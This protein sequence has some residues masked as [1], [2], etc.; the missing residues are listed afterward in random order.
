MTQCKT[1]E[2]ISQ[3]VF[4]LGIGKPVVGQFDGGMISSD[5]GLVL[6]RQADERMQLS[7]QIGFCLGDPRKDTLVRHQLVSIIRQRLYAIAAG[8]E[9]VNDANHL[10]H[11]AMHQVAVG[12]RPGIM[13]ASQPTIS[14]V[15]NRVTREEI[16]FLQELLVHAYVQQFKKAP[17]KVVLDMDT[18]C[19]EVHGNQQLSF[20]NGFYRTYCYVPLFI[21]DQSGFPLAAL[22]RSGQAGPA[23]G[24]LRMLKQVVGKLR[25][26]WPK[27][28][29]ELRADA[30]F[31]VPEFYDFCESNNVTYFIALKTNHAL[32]CLSEDLVE[33]TRTKW[34]ALFGEG[35]QLVLGRLNKRVAHKYLL[36]R[37][38]FIRGITKAE[39]RMQE[40]FENENYIKI[41]DEFLYEARTWPHPRRV[42]ARCKYGP[43]GAQMRYVVTNSFSGRPKWIYEEKYCQRCQCE[44]WI[45]ELKLTVKCDRLSCQEFNA[46]QFRLLLHSFAYILLLK[47]RASLPTKQEL[48]IETIRLRFLKVGVLVKATA[49]KIW[50][51]WA[52]GY[53]WQYEFG[54]IAARLVT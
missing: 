52:S 50:L 40:Q 7:E 9:D 15:E 36:K 51:H 14:R 11:D 44:N 49:R 46:N 29:I 16:E 20:W 26:A 35:R 8:Y 24:G 30:G 27:V 3:L 45:K 13:L 10:R 42:I 17:R 37:E 4:E 12:K 39:G 43:E 38:E 19:D 21:F 34:Q 53:P 47:L 2:T 25:E 31:C 6:L 48:S 18:T 5:G 1:E 33:R 28:V 54:S 41:V 22:L 32:E 23:Q